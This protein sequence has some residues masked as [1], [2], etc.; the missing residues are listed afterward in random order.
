MSAIA[1]VSR[2]LLAQAKLQG[3]DLNHVYC[4]QLANSWYI[5]LPAIVSLVIFTVIAYR[6]LLHPLS[7]F[8]GPFLAKVSGS[9]RNTRFWRG[10]WH[11]DVL[12]LHRAYGPVVRVAPN[13]LSIVDEKALK[14]LYGHGT[15]VLKTSWYSTWQGRDEASGIFQTQNKTEH[16]FL[17][18]VC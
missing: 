17:R 7:K 13:E 6:I 10:S 8:P 11:D 15:K 3:F 14:L 18:K 16:S 4:E 9:W 2:H 5:T 1:E 12:E